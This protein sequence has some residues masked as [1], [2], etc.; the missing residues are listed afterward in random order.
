MIRASRKKKLVILNE[1]GRRMTIEGGFTGRIYAV[2]SSLPNALVDNGFLPIVSPVA[3]SEEFDF[4]NVDGDRAPLCL[5]GTKS[6]FSKS[7]RLILDRV[8][9]HMTLEE[10]N[11]YPKLVGMKKFCLHSL[12]RLKNRYRLGKVSNPPHLHKACAAQ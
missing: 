11:N 5:G 9:P 7:R 6:Y 12:E 4:L 3:L 1:K 10:A 8:L 2:D